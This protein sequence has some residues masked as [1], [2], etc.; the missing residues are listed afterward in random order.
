MAAPSGGGTLHYT[1]NYW[2]FHE[3][4]FVERSA[5]GPIP[6][7]GFDDWPITYADLE[8]YYTKVEWEVGV[9]GSPARAPS[10]RRAP[11]PIRC[12]PCR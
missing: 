12:R 2:R 6:G 7:T 10:I 3:I 5:L 4:D 8:P 11:S 9:S 1:A